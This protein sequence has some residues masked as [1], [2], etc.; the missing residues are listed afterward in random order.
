MRDH[1]VIQVFAGVVMLGSVIAMT[2][3]LQGGFAPGIDSHPPA[4]SGWGAARETLS[5]LKSGGQV[6]VITRD[7][8]EFKNPAT[9]LQLASFR[10]ELRRANVK[11]D[12]IHLL[13]TDPLRPLEVPPGDFVD[14]LHKAP[15]GSVIVSFM[16]PPVLSAVQK[17]Q[18]G[19]IQSAVV[20]FCPGGLTE[21]I[22]LQPLFE[23]ALLQAAI[24]SRK[25]PL[26]VAK[27]NNLQGWFDQNYLVVTPA[28][29]GDLAADHEAKTL[30]A[31]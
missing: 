18:L 11:L 21:R 25:G 23:Q 7:T 17:K 22:K 1:K 14:C 5:R 31:R 8:S 26:P 6:V 16:G 2:V 10:K 19:E 9:D 3:T 4:A 13:Q 12:S 30:A 15:P 29:A 28:N 24:V 20:A 27:S